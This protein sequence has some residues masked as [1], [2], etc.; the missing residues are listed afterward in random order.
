MSHVKIPND[1]HIVRNV[2]WGRLRKDEHDNVI[3][4]TAFVMREGEST[5]STTWL[6][7]FSGSR[8][9]Q[10]R[11]AVHAMRA[12]DLEIKPKSGFVIG[13]VNEIAATVAAAGSGTISV[14]HER[15]DD[16]KAHVAIYNWPRDA[17][18]LFELLAQGPWS[19][20]VLNKD[21][22]KGKAPAPDQSAWQEPSD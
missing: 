7:Y 1:H 22:P 11:A 15:Q 3:G 4:V 19:E 14:L 10:V 9:E 21:I 6:E 2:P 13:S 20:L 17:M 18:E 16:N 8:Q 12:S 5:L